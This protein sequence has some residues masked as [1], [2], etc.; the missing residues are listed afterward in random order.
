MAIKMLWIREE[1]EMTQKKTWVDNNRKKKRR[2][3]REYQVKEEKKDTLDMLERRE[4]NPRKLMEMVLIFI[5][6]PQFTAIPSVTY[7]I[8]RNLN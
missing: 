6:V 4:T 3:R 7:D 2:S 5:G 8:Y 1:D